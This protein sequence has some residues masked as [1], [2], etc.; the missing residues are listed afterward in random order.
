MPGPTGAGKKR[1]GG[2][3][4]RGGGA[5]AAAAPSAAAPAPPQQQ[6]QQLKSIGLQL[7]K[8]SSLISY[9]FLKAH[10]VREDDQQQQ[11]GQDE[12]QQHPHKHAVFVTGLPLGLE[13][14]D[15]EA[16]F[17]CFGGVSQVVLHNT[18]RSGVV[19]FEDARASSAAL[20]AAGSGQV[21][22][23]EPDAPEG[24]RGLKAW[25]QRHKAQRPGTAALQKQLDDWVAHWEEEEAARQREREA[26]MAGDGWTVVVRSKGRKRAREA[27][28]VS[29]VSGGIAQ[30]AAQAAAEGSKGK[31]YEDFYRFQQRD[32]RRNELVD[33]RTRF[34]EDRK[35]IA[36]LRASR[37]FKPY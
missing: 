4:S 2:S 35:R 32:K 20:A 34:Q 22:E 12:Q 23:F 6:Q 29:T 9:I 16:V 5:S 33:L 11:Q 25:V 19:V 28:G 15:V 1:G 27:A 36:E 26:A 8:D 31:P 21:I 7:R 13:E 17:S 18:K 37:N 24:P 3:G 10:Q 30:A 14:N